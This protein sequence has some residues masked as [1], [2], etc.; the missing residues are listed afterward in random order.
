MR[1]WFPTLSIGGLPS[2]SIIIITTINWILATGVWNDT[3]LWNDS[4]PWK[5]A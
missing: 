2:K 4:Q 1:S 3:A 5:D